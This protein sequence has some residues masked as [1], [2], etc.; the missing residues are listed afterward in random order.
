MG[1]FSPTVL[2]LNMYI[3]L[4]LLLSTSIP[5]L[6][7][8]DCTEREDDRPEGC[9][10]QP[11]IAK[12]VCTGGQ[13][14]EC[15]DRVGDDDTACADVIPPD[16]LANVIS[17]EMS[18]DK[19]KEICEASK[20]SDN[21]TTKCEYY[22]WEQDNTTY[23]HCTLMKAGQCLVYTPCE[24][25]HCSSGQAGCTGGELGPGGNSCKGGATFG[26]GTGTVH[27]VCVNPYGQGPSHID[28][29]GG[30]EIPSGTICLTVHRCADFDDANDDLDAESNKPVNEFVFRN[31]VVQCND[32]TI[33]PPVLDG[34]WMRYSMSDNDITNAVTEDT[35]NQLK[36]PV[37]NV[38]PADL[39]LDETKLH[40]SGVNL[41]CSKQ[42]EE[43]YVFTASEVIIKKHNTCLLLCNFHHVLT[44]K[45][46]LQPDGSSQWTLYRSSPGGAVEEVIGKEGPSNT[47]VLCW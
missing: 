25:T 17:E 8:N 47:N 28:I 32:A 26:T 10:D 2:P 9:Y 46:T 5:S 37:C 38:E 1:T 31:L 34:T 21:T 15:V 42:D 4:L 16:V 39:I 3:S 18:G 30:E 40:K 6:H 7:S 11:N 23:Q 27:W 19:C 35:P 45:P 20:H 29:Y 13:S 43:H 24:G 44:I 41:I 14:C 33:D 36:D 22:R 12:V